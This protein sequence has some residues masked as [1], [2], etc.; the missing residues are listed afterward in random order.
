MSRRSSAGFTL[1]EM[2]MVI[3][4]TG[5]IAGMVAVFIKPAIDS[6]FNTISRAVLTDEADAAIRFVA[7]DLRSALPN[8]ISCSGGGA[9]FLQT[10][11][12]GRFR[13]APKSDGSGV[14]L[15]FG[16]AMTGF[17]M[18]GASAS[19]ATRD[20]F[21]HSITAPSNNVVVGN[22]SSGVSSCNSNYLAFAGNAG[23]LS[24]VDTG[25]ITLAGNTTAPLACDLE[26]AT[27]PD[28]N[29]REFG[30]FYVVNSNVVSYVCNNASGL[31]RNGVLLIDSSHVSNCVISCD[32]S[33]AY[34]QMITLNLSLKD[35][36]SETISLLRRLTI[37]NRP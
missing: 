17:D 4:I 1:V 37:A 18:I 33:K 11:A 19:S 16:V 10:R 24:V 6:Y 36:N 2:V 32:D 14:P 35:K 9:Q 13:E 25:S 29:L 30:R 20:A 27:N 21:G 23:A 34:T 7:R 28:L 22:L 12:G 15:Q 8:S 5:I 3:V 31:T 26:S